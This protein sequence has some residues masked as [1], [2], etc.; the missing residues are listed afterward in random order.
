LYL[1]HKW[2]SALWGTQRFDVL[3]YIRILKSYQHFRVGCRLPLQA[4]KWLAALFAATTIQLGLPLVLIM[5]RFVQPTPI[6]ARRRAAGQRVGSAQTT[7]MAANALPKRAMQIPCP[8]METIRIGRHPRPWRPQGEVRGQLPAAVDV[9]GA[10]RPGTRTCGCASS[11]LVH[12]YG[13]SAPRS[14][15]EDVSARAEPACVERSRS[16]ILTPAR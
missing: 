2:Y 3:Q 11:A 9:D 16:S 7:P 12:S 1:F 13:P 8:D 14:E 15:P 4:G 10:G 6:R 5:N